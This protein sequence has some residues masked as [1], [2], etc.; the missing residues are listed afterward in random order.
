MAGSFMTSATLSGVVSTPF[1]SIEIISCGD[2]VQQL[3]LVTHSAKSII[4]HSTPSV[5]NVFSSLTA[6]IQHGHWQPFDGKLDDLGLTVFQKRI[7][8]GLN[9]VPC[10]KTVSYGT[11]AKELKTGPRAL[12]GALRRNPLPIL[13][14]CHRVVAAEGLGGFMGST[15]DDAVAIKRWLIDHE[16]QAR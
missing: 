2:Q 9:R 7:Y 1:G 4:I 16:K 10:A 5:E 8:L 13:L 15:Y 14:P 3:R 6:Y 11:L 12:A